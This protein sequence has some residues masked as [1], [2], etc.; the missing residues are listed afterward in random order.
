MLLLCASEKWL[1]SLYIYVSYRT[2]KA[3]V[4]LFWITLYQ[5]VGLSPTTT[6][7][8][9][10]DSYTSVLTHWWD[11]RHLASDGSLPKRREREK[12]F[13]WNRRRENNTRV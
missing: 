9:P 13:G 12:C 4:S 2:I 6:T 7:L 8:C 5:Y 1:K 10:W 11:S 3:G